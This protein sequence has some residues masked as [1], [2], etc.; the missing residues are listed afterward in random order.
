MNQ[1]PCGSGQS[2]ADCC[3]PLISGRQAASTAEALMRARYTA[4]TL[5]E[6]GYILETIHPDKRD[7]HDEAAVLKW[8]RGSEWLGLDVLDT[9]EG[10]PDHQEGKVEFIARYKQKGSRVNHHE[11]AAFKKMEDKWYFYDGSVPDQKQVIRSGPKIGRNEPC[12]CGSG[13]KYKKCCGGKG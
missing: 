10:G 6:S 5:A 13:K 11:L 8:A 2:Y 7:A 1:C 12:P 9:Q 3:E 4:F